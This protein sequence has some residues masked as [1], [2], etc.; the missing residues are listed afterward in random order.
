MHSNHIERFRSGKTIFQEGEAGTKMYVVKEGE[1]ELLVH[2]KVIAELETGSIFGEMAI[3]D[4]KPRSATARA[5]TRCKLIPMNQEQ[6]LGLVARNP[7]FSL[8]VMKVLADRLRLMDE[9]T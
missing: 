2:G 9:R 7:G 6:F 8:E 1:V 4:G 3:I 5:K